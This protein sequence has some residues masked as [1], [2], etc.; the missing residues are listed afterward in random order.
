VKQNSIIAL[1]TDVGWIKTPIDIR[2]AV[3]SFFRNHFNSNSWSHPK[4][5]GLQFP[6]LSLE[7]K[8]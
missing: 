3:V 2:Q 7:D 8:Q 4:L 1:R 6:M 5:D